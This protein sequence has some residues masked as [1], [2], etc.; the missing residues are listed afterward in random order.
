MENGLI[1]DLNCPVFQEYL[2][3]LAGK[4]T[5]GI[6]MCR[7]ED[8]LPTVTENGHTYCILNVEELGF[9]LPKNENE[10]QDIL[11]Y[12]LEQINNE[13]LSMNE[14]YNQMKNADSVAGQIDTIFA[15]NGEAYILID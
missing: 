8:A 9:E 13:L 15:R 5:H 1:V 3:D 10:A 7:V 6:Y 11:E 4:V 2:E 14:A 12:L